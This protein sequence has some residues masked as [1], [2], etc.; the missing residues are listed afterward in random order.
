MTEIQDTTPGYGPHDLTL[1]AIGDVDFRA[2]AV[3]GGTLA[4]MPR[5][6]FI[7]AV[8]T[9]LGVIVIDKAELPIVTDR[10]KP[11]VL[12]TGD[13]ARAIVDID[14]V[15]LRA[16]GLA[17][18]ALAAHLEAHPPVDEAKVE[19]LGVL[20][21]DAVGVTAESIASGVKVNGN[22]DDLAR[23]LLATGRIAVTS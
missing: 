13:D 15:A 12:Y 10:G 3:G 18:I 16:E 22:S 6:D 20:I 5:A 9:E 19:A 11:G 17:C 8:E 14:P 7:A 2:C 23:A 21:R 4:T 1:D